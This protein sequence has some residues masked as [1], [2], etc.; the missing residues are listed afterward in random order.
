MTLTLTIAAFTACSA[1]AP[2][3]PREL[4][5]RVVPVATQPTALAA[6]PAG[7]DI[8]WV[9]EQAGR[10]LR[11]EAGGPVLALDLTSR[12][13]SGGETG[14]LG[15]AFAPE[16]PTDP[17]VFVNYTFIDSGQLSTKIASFRSVDGGLTLD[18]ASE[19]AVLVVA[20]PW[21]NHN[22]GPL[23]FGPDGMLYVALGDGGAGG[24][25]RGTGQDR[26]DLLGSLLRLDVR[27]AP[28][29]IPADQPF[30]ARSA[31]R[32]EVWAYG[33]RNPW[34]M[35]FDGDVLWFAD[36]GQNRWEEVNRAVAGGNHGWNRMEGTH[37]F[38]TSPCTGDFIAPV[39]EYGHDEGASVTGGLVYRGP[40]IPRLDGK[41]VFADF[42]TG[43]FFAVPAA[44][45]PL[46]RLGKT[47]LNPSAFGRTR[48][49]RLFVAHYGGQVLR[50]DAP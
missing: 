49:G 17:R 21:S 1:A 37:C 29:T 34:G 14:L 46:E 11:L 31:A 30:T 7:P 41:Y 24:D 35:H 27:T 33:V 45:G 13:Q 28:Y 6:P 38:D 32:P 22:S 26:S 25:P 47:E 2:S 4:G 9:T 50:I 18:P 12:V 36:V 39:A 43:R 15:L 8:L 5:F 40:S 48:D 16:W 42:A 3:S 44:G 19:V 23:A 10:L 20:Q